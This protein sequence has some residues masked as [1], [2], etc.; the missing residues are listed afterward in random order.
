MR[1]RRAKRLAI[2]GLILLGVAGLIVALFAYQLGLDN[3]QHIGGRRILLA[4]L[5]IFSFLC[6]AGLSVSPVVTHLARRAGA[7]QGFRC[8]RRG[9]GWL[10]RRFAWLNT[11]ADWFA[12]SLPGRILHRHPGWWALSGVGL[13]ILVSGWYITSGTLTQWFSYTRYFDQQANA[14]L[15]GQLS[16]QEVPPAELLALPDPYDW[17]VRER[18]NIR[19][20]I[21]DASLYHGKY[22]LYWGPVPALLAASVKLVSPV[23]VEDQYLLYFFICGLSLAL[24]GLLHWLR[25]ILYPSAPGWS[26]LLLILVGGLS[27]PVFWLVN[28]PSAYETAIAGGQ[29][30]LVLGLLAALRGM[31]GEGHRRGWLVLAGFAWGAA[32]GCRADTLLAIGWMAGMACLYLI[33]QARGGTQWIGSAACLLLPLAA[34]GGGLGWYNYARFGNP[35]ESGHR[36]QLTGPALPNNYQ[37]VF[38]AAYIPPN[39][40]NLLARPLEVRW[41]QFP[42]VFAPYITEKMWPGFIRLSPT[43]YYSEPVAGIFLAIPIFW[44]VLLPVGGLLERAWGWLNEHPPGVSRRVHPLAH[45]VWVILGGALLVSTG[46]LSIFIMTT[47]RYEADLVPLMTGLAALSLWWALDWL[48]ARPGL[49]RLLQLIALLLGLA[50]IAIGLLVN[51]QNGDK[52]FEANNP[53]LYYAIA[54]FFNGR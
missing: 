8:L 18:L 7:W 34:W 6:A 36:Y 5:S 50:A 21:W 49:R 31:A 29:F 1:M 25:K 15:A 33:S 30:F 19:N 3:N 35:L 26:V 44:L 47:M 48:K 10:E 43:Y 37:D 46:L 12:N 45:W 9:A 20:Y 17:Q 2:V 52:R 16:L 40:Y 54:H 14:F 4:V 27:A 13:V 32:I 53:A 24:A 22:Y 42:F 11:L 51:F 41:G 28:R 23:I 39:L 38:S